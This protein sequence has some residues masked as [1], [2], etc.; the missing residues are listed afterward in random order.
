[1]CCKIILGESAY[2]VVDVVSFGETMF[3]LTTAP[4]VRLEHAGQ[5][6]IYIGGTESN[7]LACLSRLN[8]KTRWLSALPA[9]PMGRRLAVDW[10]AHGVDTAHVVSA[11]FTGHAPPHRVRWQSREPARLEV[12]ARQAGQRVRFGAAD[13]D[14][15]LPGML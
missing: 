12:Q 2:M 10:S 13:I 7:A 15:E 3:R 14:L 6:Q 1:M 8:F 5:L 9:N 4:G 11:Q